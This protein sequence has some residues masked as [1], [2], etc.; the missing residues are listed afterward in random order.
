MVESLW[1]KIREGSTK[2]MV[3][4]YYRPPDQGEPVE[5][6]FLLQLQEARSQALVPAEGK[7]KQTNKKKPRQA[8][9]SPGDSWDLLTTTF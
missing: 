7:T 6:A 5:E 1:V 8:A 9:S 3:G 2:D 4:V